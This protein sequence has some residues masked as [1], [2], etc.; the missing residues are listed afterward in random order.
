MYF[1]VVFSMFQLLF[2][3]LGT[4]LRHFWAVLGGLQW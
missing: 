1:G 3:W 4:S 2:F